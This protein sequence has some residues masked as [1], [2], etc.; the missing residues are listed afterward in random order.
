MPMRV[1]VVAVAAGLVFGTLLLGGCGGS[2][3]S[4]VS[5]DRRVTPAKIAH[6][7]ELFQSGPA[8]RGYGCAFCHTLGAADA[9][10]PFGPSLDG[11]G[12]E[13]RT[14]QHWSDRQIRAFVLHQ[15]SHATCENPQD[16]SRC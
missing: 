9:T 16:P 15:I 3:S 10:G 5:V 4:T 8:D 12:S 7:R 14:Q 11:E 2:G 13:Y 6:G 1:Y